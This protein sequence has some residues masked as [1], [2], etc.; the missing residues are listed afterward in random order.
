MRR[1]WLL[2]SVVGLFVAG[3]SHKGSETNLAARLP[4][5]ITSTTDAN[6]N[7]HPASVGFSGS[8]VAKCQDA[9]GGPGAPPSCTINGAIVYK[10]NSVGANGTVTLTCNGQA[11]L[12]CVAH[13]SA[14]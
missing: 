2:I 4:V 8:A 11:P 14:Q 7:Q 12:R 10:G 3:C 6:G 5:T 13:I 1:Q 9:V